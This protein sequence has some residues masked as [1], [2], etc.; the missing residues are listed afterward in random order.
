MKNHCNQCGSCCKAIPVNK[1]IEEIKQYHKK[2]PDN[3]DFKFIVENF[4]QITKEDAFIINPSLKERFDKLPEEL[5]HTENTSFFT[6]KKLKDNKCTSYE[7][8]P[9]LCSSYPINHYGHYTLASLIEIDMCGY[10]K[11]EAIDELLAELSSELKS[12]VI[13]QNKKY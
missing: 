10:S 8:R 13:E 3:Y 5:K 4:T 2:Y 1:N 11:K 7:E 9:P 12:Y 6:C